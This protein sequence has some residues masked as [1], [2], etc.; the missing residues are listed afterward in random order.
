MIREI[1]YREKR[2]SSGPARIVNLVDKG[3]LVVTLALVAATVP[4]GALQHMRFAA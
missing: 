3:P 2:A 1:N 4:S